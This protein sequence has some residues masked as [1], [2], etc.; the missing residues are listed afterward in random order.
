MMLAAPV[1]GKNAVFVMDTHGKVS[2]F[3]LQTGKR[4]WENSLTANIGG[5]K[6]TKSR[7]SGLAFDDSLQQRGSEACLR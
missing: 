5:F 6:D 1:S 3:N 4:L 7:A 2:A